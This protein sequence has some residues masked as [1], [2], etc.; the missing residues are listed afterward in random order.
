MNQVGRRHRH[1]QGWGDREAILELELPCSYLGVRHLMY[2][3]M[4]G[5]KPHLAVRLQ[6]LCETPSSVG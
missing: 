1:L 4:M 2:Y 6:F 5:K 3:L